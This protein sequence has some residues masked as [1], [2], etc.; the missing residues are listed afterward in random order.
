MSVAARG[1]EIVHELGYS[2]SG[3]REVPWNLQQ[4]M[5]QEPCGIG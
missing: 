1:D 5:A 2:S 3:D 4:L